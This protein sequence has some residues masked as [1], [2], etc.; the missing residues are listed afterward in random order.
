MEDRSLVSESW[1]GLARPVVLRNPEERTSVGIVRASFPGAGK[2]QVSLVSSRI[3]G[4]Q[5]EASVS[6]SSMLYGGGHSRSDPT[7]SSDPYHPFLHLGE[8]GAG[9][10]VG[11]GLGGAGCCPG[12]A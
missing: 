9:E 1:A 5:E 8:L 12:P 6:P 4:P 11:G 2:S 3:G 7:L 10:G